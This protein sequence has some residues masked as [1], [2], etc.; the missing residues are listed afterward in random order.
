MTRFKSL[1]LGLAAL[2]AVSVAGGMVY[3][4]DKKGDDRGPHAGPGAMG[5]QKPGHHAKGP[6]CKRHGE[7][8]GMRRDRMGPPHFRPDP[9]RMARELS[10]ME[11]AIG[12][13]AEQLDTWRDF[14]DALQAMM[15]K[16]PHPGHDGPAKLDE[17]EPFWMAEKFA[18]RT[19]ERADAAQKLKDAVAKLR[20]TL[21]PEQL[22]RAK[23]YEQG[24]L[25]RMRP[26]RWGDRG[27]EGP[28]Q[29]KWKHQ[30]RLG[31]KDHGAM[32]GDDAQGEMEP[33]NDQD[34]MSPS[35]DDA[36]M[37]AP[38]DDDAG[39]TAPANPDEL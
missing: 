34:Q 10:T 8:H 18:D 30:E 13:R 12:I 25:D 27:G 15:P 14:T 37:G 24:V 2:L 3:A 5:E 1:A 7:R 36:G 11:T 9:N 26:H 4:H 39:E 33:S 19:L 31:D 22:D 38:D 17:N 28:G 35:E 16:P 20:E 29:M 32:Q 23:T 21:T 6:G